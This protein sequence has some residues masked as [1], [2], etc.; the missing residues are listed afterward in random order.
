MIPKKLLLLL[1]LEQ[2]VHWLAN[3]HSQQKTLA[4]KVSEYVYGLS[5]AHYG[6]IFHLPVLGLEAR[7]DW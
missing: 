1:L 5:C 4:V 3:L 2:Q 6:E 7:R